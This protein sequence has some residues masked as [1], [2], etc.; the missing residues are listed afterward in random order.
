MFLPV[1]VAV[2]LI[3]GFVAPDTDA[4]PPVSAVPD[5]SEFAGRDAIIKKY[6]EIRGL[7]ITFEIL[8]LKSF[9]ALQKAY[10]IKGMSKRTRG[11]QNQFLQLA[12]AFRDSQ[13]DRIHPLLYLKDYGLIINERIW[14]QSRL[15]NWTKSG[16]AGSTDIERRILALRSKSTDALTSS[17]SQ[18]ADS[19]PRRTETDSPPANFTGTSSPPVNI[20][21][22]Q[23]GAGLGISNAGRTAS[24]TAPFSGASQGKTSAPEPPHPAGTSAG[25]GLGASP[26]RTTA[27]PANLNLA[28]E[29]SR[30]YHFDRSREQMSEADMANVTEALFTG[31]DEEHAG[32]MLAEE[33]RLSAEAGDGSRVLIENVSVSD[34]PVL[35]ESRITVRVR[36]RNHAERGPPAVFE[37]G[38]WN[39]HKNNKTVARRRGL[40][41]PP[42]AA[43]SFSLSFPAPRAEM[44]GGYVYLDPLNDSR[45]EY[46]TTV[47]HIDVAWNRDTMADKEIVTMLRDRIPDMRF[48]LSDADALPWVAAYRKRGRE[49]VRDFQQHVMAEIRELEE[50][51]R[52]AY[53]NDPDFMADMEA[54]LAAEANTRRLAE[55]DM[56]HAWAARQGEINGIDLVSILEDHVYIDDNARVHGNIQA[57]RGAMLTA[58]RR[59]NETLSSVDRF[60][61]DYGDTAGT[62]GTY[63]ETEPFMTPA[64]AAS[65]FVGMNEGLLTHMGDRRLQELMA[66][67]KN[68]LTEYRKAD[69]N[70]VRFQKDLQLLRS[71]FDFADKRLG[72]ALTGRAREVYRAYHDKVASQ[73]NRMD[74]VITRARE[75]QQ[76]ADVYLRRSRGV[77]LVS[78][79]LEKMGDAWNWYDLYEKANARV[80]AGED[81]WA[82]FGKEYGVFKLK[83]LVGKVPVVG[84]ADAVMTAAGQILYHR[85]REM[86]DELGI[87]PRQYTASTLVDMGGGLSFAYVEDRMLAAGARSAKFRMTADERQFAEQRLNLLEKRMETATDP[88]QLERLGNAR[89]MLREVLREGM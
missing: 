19:R 79:G 71:R 70:P 57:A 78:K 76:K 50:R 14:Q 89:R 29:A 16:N 2:C 12:K 13:T 69:T 15:R 61:M 34:R 38:I 86:W 27:K 11:L 53:L 41:L 46:P 28:A 68:L 1:I 8:P 17:P 51:E 40:R 63:A 20:S 58:L 23:I 43:D 85:D 74:N 26:Q 82:A 60:L 33:E 52:V 64:L 25:L 39:Y 55:Y 6:F 37:L 67:Y 65:G 35:P 36:V 7:N 22:P 5:A 62:T 73:L 9:V 66:E 42:G 59:S 30:S 3:G 45:P 21:P 18:T 84:A 31:G 48:T 56:Q 88:I 4:M 81:M 87:D 75:F 47:I 72:H 77:R 80:R 49:A 44:F 54:T 83:T 10:D 32:Q 24:V